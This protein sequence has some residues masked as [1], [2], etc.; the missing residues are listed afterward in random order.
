MVHSHPKSHFFTA[1]CDIKGNQ[2]EDWVECA[3]CQ[4]VIRGRDIE[5]IERGG[6]YFE[7]IRKGAQVWTRRQ[8][9]P[10]PDDW[11]ANRLRTCRSRPCRAGP[12]SA[13]KG[14]PGSCLPASGP[15]PSHRSSGNRPVSEEPMFEALTPF[16]FRP[17][18]RSS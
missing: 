2:V 16:L 5:A 11:A 7:K 4:K 3:H 9:A 10:I 17:T 12:R 15:R 13:S 8:D 18:L 1:I 14:R 6:W